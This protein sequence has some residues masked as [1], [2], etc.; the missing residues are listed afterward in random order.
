MGGDYEEAGRELLHTVVH[1]PRPRHVREV[2]TGRF[3][4]TGGTTTI[5]L[6]PGFVA[7]LIGIAGEFD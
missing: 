3:S 5:N 2:E 7:Y 6:I 4:H 1:A